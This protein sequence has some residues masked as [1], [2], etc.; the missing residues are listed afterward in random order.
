VWVREVMNLRKFAWQE[1][2]G[3]FTVSPT[4]RLGVQK[5][6]ANQVEHHRAKTFREEFLE[7]LKMAGV[8]YE[9]RFLD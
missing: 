1:G 3:A 2:Y 5:Y 9:N 7:F 6:I 8:K 4:S